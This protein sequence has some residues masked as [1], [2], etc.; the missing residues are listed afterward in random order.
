MNE[1]FVGFARAVIVV[2]PMVANGMTLAQA[3]GFAEQEFRGFA[4]GPP[5]RGVALDER[6]VRL[7]GVAAMVRLVG[8]VPSECAVHLRRR[9]RRIFTMS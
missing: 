7:A 3:T 1:F 2:V 5:I 8:G 6:D 9:P 4:D